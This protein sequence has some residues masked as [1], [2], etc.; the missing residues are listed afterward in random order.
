MQNK[1]QQIQENWNNTLYPIRPPRLNL[2]INNNDRNK[3]KPK[4]LQKLNN[5]L[6]I[7]FRIKEEIKKEIKDL[8]EFNEY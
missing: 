3:R 6:L 1:Y 5:S 7:D 8:L 4:N 2:D